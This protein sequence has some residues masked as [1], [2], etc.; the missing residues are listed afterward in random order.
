MES[1]KFIHKKTGE[2]VTQIDIMKLGEYTEYY[3]TCQ[4]CGTAMD[5]YGRCGYQGND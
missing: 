2:I 5:K 3:G 1:Q 4:N